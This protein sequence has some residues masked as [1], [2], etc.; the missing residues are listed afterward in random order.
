MSANSG[1]SD[2][3]ARRTVTE[4]PVLETMP[5]VRETGCVR[6]ETV[7]Y[8]PLSGGFSREGRHSAM[9]S[10]IKAAVIGGILTAIGAIIAAGVMIIPEMVKLTHPELEDSAIA[11]FKGE[12]TAIAA[13]EEAGSENDTSE[14]TDVR[15]LYNLGWKYYAGDGTEQ[16]YAL[17]R[18]YFEQAAGLGDDDALNY[19]GIIYSSGYGVEQNYD[20]ARTYYEQAAEKENIHALNN[21]GWLYGSGLGV[22]QDYGK[23]LEYYEQAAGKGDASAIYTIG[24]YYN[25]GYGVERDYGIARRYYEQAAGMGHSNA[26]YN[27]AI[28]YDDGKGVEQNDAAALFYYIQA[29]GL[30]NSSAYNNVG[31]MYEYGQGVIQDYAAAEWYYEQSVKKGDSGNAPDNLARVQEKLNQS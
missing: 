8:C 3:A 23:A 1:D 25:E 24:V 9:D 26:L 19:L 30:G 14:T 2:S 6:S 12:S 27:L 10:T 5:D 22:A 28:L 11:A 31:V 16:D 7:I 18:E 21:L 13:P 4:L 20:T 15:E 29:A 17:A